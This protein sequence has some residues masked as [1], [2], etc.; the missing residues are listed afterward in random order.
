[1]FLAYL[2]FSTDSTKWV[3][4]THSLVPSSDNTASVKSTKL[5]NL[6][7]TAP[8]VFVNA[9]NLFSGHDVYRLDNSVRCKNHINISNDKNFNGDGKHRCRDPENKSD[10]QLWLE[11]QQLI[12]LP[13][14]VPSFWGVCTPS[15][16]VRLTSKSTPL[17]GQLLQWW[18]NI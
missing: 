18:N 7:P 2:S 3:L 8:I 11:K 13:G 12:W 17:F 14:A 10:L 1:M 16:P 6:S 9:S 15:W 5:S 4:L